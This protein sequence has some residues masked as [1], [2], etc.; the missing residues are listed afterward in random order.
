VTVGRKQSAGWLH[1][2]HHISS[3][4][5]EGIAGATGNER[6]EDDTE[7]VQGGRLAGPDPQASLDQVLRHADE[8]RKAEGNPPD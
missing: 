2:R 6:G 4:P 3:A 7:R 8:A 1:R 5:P